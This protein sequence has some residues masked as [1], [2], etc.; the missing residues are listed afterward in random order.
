MKVRGCCWKSKDEFMK[1]M[2]VY[3]KNGASPFIGFRVVIQ[4]AEKGKDK[5]PF[6]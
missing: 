3:N 5:N 1:M 4:N 2:E 6:W